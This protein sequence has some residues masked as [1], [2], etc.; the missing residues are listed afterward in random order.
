MDV[1]N[2][3]LNSFILHVR[4]SSCLS[5]YLEASTDLS[6]ASCLL[7]KLIC[8]CSPEMKLDKQVHYPKK[9]NHFSSNFFAFR[10]SKNQRILGLVFLVGF[11]FVS[12]ST[13]YL[14]SNLRIQE[15]FFYKFHE[16]SLR[17]Q[18]KT[19]NETGS[20]IPQLLDI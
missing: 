14:L 17:I 16:N 18:T 3:I 5:P 6:T 7:H 12:F 11:L 13:R 1:Y 4:L 19:N 20:T 2:Y 9:S 10:D 15:T 8:V